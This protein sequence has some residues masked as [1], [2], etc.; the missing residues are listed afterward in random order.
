MPNVDPRIDPARQNRLVRH[1][2]DTY[3][4]TLDRIMAGWGRRG[5]VAGTEPAEPEEELGQL[6]D[7][8]EQNRKL[9]GSPDIWEAIDATRKLEQQQELENAENSRETQG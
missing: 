6:R 7:A 4:S 2:M 8:E 3:Y 1:W 5:Y 9:Q